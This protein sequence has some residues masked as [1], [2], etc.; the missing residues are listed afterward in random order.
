MNHEIVLG[1]SALLLVLSG[2][3]YHGHMNAGPRSLL[4][5]E[6]V[7]MILLS[8]A[9]ALG[10]LALF[11]PLAGLWMALQDGFTAQA[12]LGAGADLAGLALFAVS[13]LLFRTMMRSAAKTAHGPS[14]VT[15][16]TPRPAGPRHPQGRVQKKAA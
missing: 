1:G 12:L 16:F 14:T 4:K 7:E 10:P 9:V 3:L 11:G 15:P 2:L 13:A 8:L 6:M 5:S